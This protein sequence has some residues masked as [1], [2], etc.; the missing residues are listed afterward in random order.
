MEFITSTGQT[1]FLQQSNVSEARYS[2]STK[3]DE[4]KIGEL[5]KGYGMIEAPN[6]APIVLPEQLLGKPWHLGDKA[7]VEIADIQSP[8]HDWLLP[9]M[10]VERSELGGEDTF[11]ALGFEVRLDHEIGE[12]TIVA[13]P[14][15]GYFTSAGISYYLYRKGQYYFWSSELDP[16][17]AL[18]QLPSGYVVVN[19][20]SGQLLVVPEGKAEDKDKLTSLASKQTLGV[21]WTLPQMD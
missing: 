15:P 21:L 5:P 20:D 9:T 1:Y 4:S 18:A 8:G 16:T 11:V 3:R 10:G 2:W 12:T 7:L 19:W 14:K 13:F 17:L 6:A